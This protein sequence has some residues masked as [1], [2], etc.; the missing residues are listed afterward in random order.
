M[1]D[2]ILVILSSILIVAVAIEGYYLYE[3]NHKLNSK[4]AY[5]KPVAK[6]N[7]KT[8]IQN[9]TNKQIKTIDPFKQFALSNNLN[10]NPFKEF[11][12][13]QEEMNRVF[14]SFNAKFQ[15]DPDFDKFFKDFTVSPSL[16][17]KDMGDKYV[18]NV[19]IPGSKENNI[20]VSVKNHILKV[21]A[22]TSNQIDKKSSHFIQQERYI[23][24]F[25]REI[26]LPSDAD[27][28]S[29]KTKYVNGVLVITLK[30]K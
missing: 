27:E 18:I 16:D 10:I 14:G 20:K 7:I 23:G 8:N 19:N 26:T 15:N 5:Y 1:R 12:K 25:E 4:E 22:K 2:K 29:L 17:M 6:Q 28:N 9:S 3:M 30:K 13:M 24:N 11:Q 21:E